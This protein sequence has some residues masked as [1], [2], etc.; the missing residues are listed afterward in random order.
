MIFSELAREIRQLGREINPRTLEA[1]RKLIAPLHN[2]VEPPLDVDVIREV[3]YGDHDR[4]RLDIFTSSQ[5]RNHNK[6]LLIFVHGGGFIA[7]DKHTPGT[8]F[9]DNIAIWAVR[10]GFNAV[11]MT[12][13]LAPN[14]QW[15]SG[16]EDIRAVVELI[17]HKGFEFGIGASKLFLM[18]Q[19]A[20]AAHAASYVAHP[21][22]YSPH[23]HELKGLILLSGLYNFASLKASPL[24]RSYIGD[25]PAL[26]ASRS[27]L[28]GLLASNVP[29]LLTLAEMDPPIFEKQTLELMNAL[30][31]KHQQ[32]PRFVHMIGHNHL[33]VA[34]YLGLED[35]LLAPQLRNFIRDK[36]DDKVQE[37]IRYKHT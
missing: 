25:D 36:A 9:Y 7:G 8:P 1:T 30:H 15:P 11:N 6:P 22:F 31:E 28:A 27:S 32:L 18:G 2:I 24:E 21:E 26:Y 13:R 37:L 17:K 4:Q 14:F 10:N 16:I 33:S 34:L 19:S 20:G 5:N 3:E 23:T 35:D 12:Y 29:M